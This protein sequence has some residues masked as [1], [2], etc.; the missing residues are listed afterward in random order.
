MEQKKEILIFGWCDN[1]NTDSLFTSHLAATMLRLP[2]LGVEGLGMVQIVGNQIARQ[3]QD[4]LR[5]FEKTNGDWLLWVDSDIVLNL[6]S[7]KLLWDNRDAEKRPVVS[8]VYF[9]TMEMNQALPLPLPCI[10]TDVGEGANQS[11]HP[12]P[13]NQLIPIDVAGLGFCLMHKSVAHKL[14]EAY[15]DTTF[16]IT[17]DTNHVSEDVS[18]FRKLKA[19]GIPVY[20]HTGALVQHIKRFVFDVNYYNLWWNTVSPLRA[21]AEAMK[22]DTSKIEEE[23]A[24]AEQ[25]LKSQVR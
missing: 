14:R 10:F 17:I 21:E 13:E 3:R 20:A 2:S 1:G 22:I 23:V 7:F 12:L 11:I 25:E 24:K 18:F 15:G 9:I 8:G 6:E 4:L 19:L 16:A 5:D